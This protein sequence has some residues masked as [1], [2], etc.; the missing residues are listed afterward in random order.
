M[1]A[2]TFLLVSLVLLFSRCKQQNGCDAVSAKA[3]STYAM[4]ADLKMQQFRIMNDAFPDQ[5]ITAA[6]QEYE[7]AKTIGERIKVADALKK[8]VVKTEVTTYL[9]ACKQQSL[10]FISHLYK[11]TPQSFDLAIQNNDVIAQQVKLLNAYFN[12]LDTGTVSA[13]SVYE[14]LTKDEKIKL[15]TDANAFIPAPDYLKRYLGREFQRTYYV[16]RYLALEQL[17][18]HLLQ[19]RFI[20]E[21]PQGFKQSKDVGQRQQDNQ[22]DLKLAKN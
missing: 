1:K 5:K 14:R 11:V 6:I 18:R 3:D 20:N 17:K 9:P 16:Q 8:E 13:I 19:K 4:L 22:F 10:D 15:L 21:F 2:T 7:K 12:D